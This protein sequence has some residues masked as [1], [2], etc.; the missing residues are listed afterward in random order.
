MQWLE[1]EI[2][3]KML[4]WATEEQ[5][6]LLAVHDAFAVRDIDGT[7]TNTRMLEV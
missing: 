1:G 2:A 4:Q 5:I 3:L 6:P 7:K